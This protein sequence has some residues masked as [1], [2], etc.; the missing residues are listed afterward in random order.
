MLGINLR[1]GIFG[2]LFSTFSS[3]ADR[4]RDVREATKLARMLTTMLMVIPVL[5]SR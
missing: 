1:A 5:Q 4:Q 2:G 3:N